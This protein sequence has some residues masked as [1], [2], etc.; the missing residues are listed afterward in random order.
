MKS[1]S[2]SAYTLRAMR[3]L[4]GV[5]GLLGAVVFVWEIPLI[6]TR[7]SLWPVLMLLAVAVILVAIEQI[8]HGGS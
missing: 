8:R 6:F 4:S 3:L 1:G 7:T 2:P 5:A